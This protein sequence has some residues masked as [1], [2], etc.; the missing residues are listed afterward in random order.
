MVMCI[1]EFLNNANE[2]HAFWIGWGEGATFFIKVRP[3]PNGY[4]NPMEKEWHYY[5][6]GRP[7][8][9][10]TSVAVVGGILIGLLLLGGIL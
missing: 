7:I 8:G 2:R 5:V 3:M 9:L 4:E 10:F 1:K 6:I